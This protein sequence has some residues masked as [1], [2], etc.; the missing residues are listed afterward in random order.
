LEGIHRASESFDHRAGGGR[1]LAAEP[2]VAGDTRLLHRH[3]LPSRTAAIA[4][5]ACLAI[6][7]RR[8]PFVPTAVLLA[9]LLAFDMMRTLSLSFGL[10][11]LMA[12]FDAAPEVG[13]KCLQLAFE[14]L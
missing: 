9:G 6:L 14:M 4:L 13:R 11:P 10:W 7:A 8:T 5:Y 2:V 3:Q 1:P 12:A